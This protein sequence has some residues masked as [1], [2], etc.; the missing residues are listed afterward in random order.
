MQSRCLTLLRGALM[1]L[2]VINC[3][4]AGPAAASAEAANAAAATASAEA[5]TAA[6]SVEVSATAPE[7]V[8]APTAGRSSMTAAELE[9]LGVRTVADALNTV[10]GLAV[11]TFGASGTQSAVSIRGATTNQVL[12]LVDGAPVS[13]PSS[14]L[15]DF[16]RLAIS[17][18]DIES[19]EV[20][21]GG[22]S[23]QYG[24]DAV[25]GV[26]LITT[27]KSQN[28]GSAGPAVDTDGRWLTV[29]ASNLSRIPF[30]AISGSGF[31]A[32][33]V[34]P[35]ALSLVDG[36]R[37]GFR[38]ELPA[39]LCL[40]G[41][42]ERAA[43]EYRYRDSNEIDRVRTNAD[44]IRGRLSAGWSGMFAGGQVKAAVSGGM[45]EMGVP[46]AVTALTPEARQSDSNMRADISYLNDALFY[47]AQTLSLNA[48]G[49]MADT[50]YK[51]TT[52]VSGDSNN[53]RRAGLDLRSS[54]LLDEK[55]SIGFGLSGR[56]D[57][58]DS[59]NVV[60]SQGMA[61]ERCSGGAYIEPQL[62]IGKWLIA[63]AFRF[64]YT[65]DFPSGCSYSLG[66]ARSVSEKIKLSI[67]ASRAYRAPSFDDLYWPSAS[68]VA[69]NPDLEPETAYSADAGIKYTEENFTASAALYARYV[70]NVILWQAGDDGVWRPS[71]WGEALYP[72][73]EFE[74]SGKSG[75]WWVRV[76][77]TYLHSY[78]LSGGLE[79]SDDKR[80]PMVPEHTFT[81][82]AGGES[83]AV[84]VGFSIK[85]EGLRYLKMA[86][87]AYE[88]SHFA[89]N[90]HMGIAVN[91]NVQIVFD[92]DNLF[93]ERYEMIV[94]YPMP[95]FSLSSGVEIKL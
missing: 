42:A 39:G 14:G 19:I 84:S 78:V 25:G 47:G 93:D 36:Q 82:S 40:S 79:L 17:V 5:E 44:I 63:P 12:V 35:S 23:A 76:S 94:G 8:P 46:G 80:V 24:A 52:A 4:I 28:A 66:A 81:L 43:N 92:A 51:E 50:L 55:N 72:G 15:A 10:A 71:N 13:D 91:K 69:G 33:T 83:G 27:K 77:Y 1:F 37:L 56:Y 58:L 89:A 62:C 18:D 49:L 60:T 31:S 16:S 59:S 21:R 61:P 2:I 53:S 95:G 68:G 38:A 3:L 88:P 7:Q 30:S 87:I 11:Q 70:Q 6:G 90:F 20:L 22:A 85:Y 32:V 75:P 74:S 86:N 73:L 34:E 65:S 41:D 57:M 45:R 64:D 54:V 29:K 9:A 26:I 48:Y 67:N